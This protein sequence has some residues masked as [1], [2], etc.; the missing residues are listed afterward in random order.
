MA[1]D[2]N[3]GR[4]A[5]EYLV[6][7]SDPNYSRDAAVLAAGNDLEAGTVLGRRTRAANGAVVTGSIATTVLTVTAV[8]SGVLS[9]GQTIS[10]SGV[11]AGTTIT[12]LGTGTGGTG[13]YTVSASQTASSTTI[14]ASAAYATAYAHNAASTGTMGAITVSSTAKLG[15]Y[16]LTIVEPGSNVG[17]YIV[18]DPDGVQIGTGIVAAAFSA[19][20]LA[21]TLA[22]GS[23]DF[24][25][26]E[27]FTITVAAGD[28]LHSAL[29]LSGSDGTQAAVSILYDNT[30]ATLAAVDCVVTARA[31]SINASELTWPTGATADQKA[32]ALAQ[33]AGLGIIAR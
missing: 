25:A 18:E 10:G 9:V 22:D 23:T 15:V 2:F 29:N 3:E 32:A 12:A 17:T 8:S 21:F 1:A 24:V 31:S 4:N 7:E 6:W 16:R 20:G 19:G 30:D 28:G 5:G 13:T 14:T 27:G 26:G 33:L 11:T